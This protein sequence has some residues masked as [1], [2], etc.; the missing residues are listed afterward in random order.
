MSPTRSDKDRPF[1]KAELARFARARPNVR[2]VRRRLQMSQAEFAA[3]FGFNVATL[4][5]WEQGRSVPDQAIRSYLR[6]IATQ[7]EVVKKALEP[8]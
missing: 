3:A 2:A 5:D 8:A 4:R 7:P 1:T 6:V